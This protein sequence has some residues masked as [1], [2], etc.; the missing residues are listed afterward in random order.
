[1]ISAGHFRRPDRR[2]LPGPYPHRRRNERM[3]LRRL[4]LPTL[5][6]THGGGPG[7]GAPVHRRACPLPASNPLLLCPSRTNHFPPSAVTAALPL[8]V[9]CWSGPGQPPGARSAARRFAARFKSRLLPSLGA[10]GCV[11]RTRTY[12]RARALRRASVRQRAA[13][14]ARRAHAHRRGARAQAHAHAR[15]RREGRVLL[16]SLLLHQ[17]APAAMLLALLACSCS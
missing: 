10:S 8:R 17:A 13:A 4:Q 2:M 9:P 5:A 6:D 16:R 1:M 7:H 3:G 14:A 12:A 15:S 11:A